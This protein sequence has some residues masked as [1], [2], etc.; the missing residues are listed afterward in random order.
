VCSLLHDPS[1]IEHTNQI[2]IT[3]R[4]NAMR[5]DQARAVTHDAAQLRK[6]FLFGVRID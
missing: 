4:G 2:R 5:H 6:N 3:H 1:F